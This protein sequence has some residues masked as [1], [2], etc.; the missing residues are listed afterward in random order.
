M[1]RNT[2]IFRVRIKVRVQA[3][4]STMQLALDSFNRCC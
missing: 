4:D 3:R 2:V 1:F